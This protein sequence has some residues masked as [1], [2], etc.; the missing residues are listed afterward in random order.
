MYLDQG[1]VVA[2]EYHYYQDSCKYT[3][4]CRIVEH[5]DGRGRLVDQHGHECDH[6]LGTQEYQAGE[7]FDLE[8]S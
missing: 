1:T 4:L 3:N 2:L 7:T 6:L 5:I 8:Q